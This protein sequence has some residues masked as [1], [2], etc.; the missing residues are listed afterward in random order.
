MTL[1]RDGVITFKLL[2]LYGSRPDTIAYNITP[3]YVQIKYIYISEHQN[4]TSLI[5][6]LRLP[7]K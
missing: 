3:L 5:Y 1:I 2:S 6:K 4:V 7:D